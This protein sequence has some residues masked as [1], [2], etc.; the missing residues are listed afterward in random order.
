MAA[1]PF[2]YPRPLICDP[3]TPGA[4]PLA[5]GWARF[6]H[7]ALLS[8]QGAPRVVPASDLPEEV[9]TRLT[10][11]RAPLAG[12]P[13]DRPRIM[14]ILNLTPDSFSD[15]GKFLA[16]EAA[17]AHARAMA[18]AGADILDLGGESTRPGAATVPVDEE[19][20]R[21]A[22]VIG[23]LAD[24]AV[25]VSIDTRKAAVARA[26]IR[27]GAKIVNDVSGLAHDPAMADEIAALGV[28]AVLMHSQGDPATMH[29]DPRYDDVVLDVYDA[30]EGILARAGAAGVPREHLVADIGIGFGKTQ[31]HNLALLRDLP[32]FHALGVP[33]L[34]GVSRK[35]FIGVIGHAQEPADRMPGSVALALRAA[36]EGV[37]I[38]RVHD[39]AETAQAFALWQAAGGPI[40]G[41][42]ETR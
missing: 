7:V 17:L 40:H 13:L 3:A 16:P 31:A 2:R 5:G 4:W 10:A 38:L 26:A 11:P 32:L 15:G 25:P 30:L 34:L 36:A 27:A 9:L 14:G 20:A 21:T 8:R 42:R 39:V 18:E 1:D 35:R 37:H 24:L 33:L 22:P 28:P 29:F 6:A 19:I 41:D 23:A 12:L